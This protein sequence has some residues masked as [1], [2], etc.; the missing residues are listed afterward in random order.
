MITTRQWDVLTIARDRLLL[1]E[2]REWLPLMRKWGGVD[3]T[4]DL[5]E[6]SYTRLLDFL[7]VRGF[8][9]PHYVETVSLDYRQAIARWSLENGLSQEIYFGLLAAVEAPDG[10]T[11]D[12]RSFQRAV[13]FFEAYGCPREALLADLKRT[14]MTPKQLALLHVARKET[15]VSDGLYR[16]ALREVGGG[17]FSASDLDEVGFRRMLVFFETEGFV[18]PGQR[19]PAKNPSFGRRPGMASPSQVTLIRDLWREW[20]GGDDE[21]A[22]NTWLERFHHVSTLR[23]LTAAKAGAVIAALK[24]MKTRRSEDVA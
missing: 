11:M 5:D 19:R 13:A 16:S 18:P 17:V 21:E 20:S 15:C 24:A 3:L 8:R 4:D 22:L 10:Y 6:A 23:F 7:I 9:D 14:I 2:E 12:G 1:T